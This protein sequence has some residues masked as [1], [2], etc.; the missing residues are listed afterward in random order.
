MSRAIVA[1]CLLAVFTGIGFYF[2][3][4]SV[5]RAFVPPPVHSDSNR[6]RSAEPSVPTPPVVV[7]QHV[8]PPPIPM[9]GETV[10]PPNIKL[11]SPIANLQPKD[12]LDTFNDSR[13]EGERRHEATDIMAPRGT[14]VLAVDDGVIKKLFTSKPGGLTIYQYD[15]T[16]RY[17]YYYAHLDRYAEGL[18]EG[19][20]VRRGD[21]IA[22][23][24]STGN[25][26]PNAP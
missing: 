13:G 10:A 8:S 5:H 16:Q 15:P 17:C 26:D 18:K 24:G 7:E 6:A 2:G 12:I 1:V 3:R 20:Q 11:S 22:Y 19:M 25:A 21:L 14:P 4:A 9:A 23:V